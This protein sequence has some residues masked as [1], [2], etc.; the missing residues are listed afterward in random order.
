MAD[1][2]VINP[3][4]LFLRTCQDLATKSKS[5]EHYMKLRMAGLLRHLLLGRRALLHMVNPGGALPI[6]F[7]YREHDEDTGPAWTSPR[8]FDAAHSLSAGGREKEGD[9]A[10]FLAAR[11]V[12]LGGQ[13]LS[14]EQLLTSVDHSYGGAYLD[15]PEGVSREALVAFDASVREGDRG[16]VAVALHDI[17]GVTLRALLPLVKGGTRSKAAG[18]AGPTPPPGSGCPFTG[19]T[20]AR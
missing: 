20:G 18:D 5:K 13:W 14:V 8:G 19:Q 3:E 10:T 6:V 11:V 4:W 15:I 1:I 16:A 12:H 17:A 7:Q 2:E 9:L